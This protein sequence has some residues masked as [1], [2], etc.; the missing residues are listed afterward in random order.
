MLETNKNLPQA[1][2]SRNPERTL[3]VLL[4]PE[5]FRQYPHSRLYGW[6]F[7]DYQKNPEKS[8]G[9]DIPYRQQVNWRIV[10]KRMGWVTWEDCKKILPESCP[11]LDT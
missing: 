2:K 9:R 4:T 8:L 7:H 11:W 5:M 1:L 3:F 6:L 10:S